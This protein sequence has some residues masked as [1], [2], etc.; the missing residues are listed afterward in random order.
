MTLEQKVGQLFVIGF[1]GYTLSD[2]VIEHIRKNHFGNVI[3]FAKNVR[4]AQTTKSLTSEIQKLMEEVCGVPGF[5]SIDQE[6][7]MVTRIFNGAT[8]MPG[9]MAFGS[10]AR[11]GE[12]Y[13]EGRYVGRELREL[14]I[15]MNLAPVLDVNSNPNNPVI[16]V[17]SYSDDPQK[18]AELASGYIRGIQSEA[19]I[20]TGKHFP[21]HG[22]TSLDSH[23]SLPSVNRCLESIKNTE[24]VP[25]RRAIE[26]GIGAI[27]TSHI[28]FPAIEP[29]KLP[30]TLSYKILTELLRHELG[31]NGLI[32]TDSLEMNAIVENFTTE[33]GT[34]K[35]FMA[36]ADLFCISHT[37]ERQAGTYEAILRAVRDGVISEK[38]L[39]ESVDRILDAKSRLKQ[40][41]FEN[42]GVDELQKHRVF[43]KKVS[44]GSIT[45][46]KDA[47]RLLPLDSKDDKTLVISTQPKVTSNAD[48]RL[49]SNTSFAEW[50]ANKT[51][52][53]SY[54]ISA[55][56]TDEEIEN[57]LV[58]A[59]NYKKVIIATYNAG[60]YTAQAKLVRELYR[61]NKNL[62]V[63]MLRNPYDIKCFPEI[64]CCVAA[65]EYTPL[66]VESV[67]EALTGK[68]PFQGVLPVKL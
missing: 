35:S 40:Q 61:Q 23:Y 46:I 8:F 51:E 15:N 33:K 11:E 64:S 27:M 30:A 53:K 57:V 52:A 45:L 18:V 28:L 63:V 36:G 62:I 42:M 9:N 60:I 6:G 26:C 3:L 37:P 50:Y 20:A 68:I 4:D 47:N 21:G 55:E 59:G 24:L 16:G 22:D 5:I 48:D 2:K 13:L 58:M 32:I 17:R 44:R 67:T 29:E 7:G 14:G 34:L 49:K 56:P 41:R 66:S 12:T 10:A 31:F 65:Y 25:F 19:V 43:A 38:R 54:T 1:D 39:D